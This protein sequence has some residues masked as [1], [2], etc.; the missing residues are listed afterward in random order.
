MLFAVRSLK[1][2]KNITTSPKTSIMGL[3]SF[4]QDFMPYDTHILWWNIHFMVLFLTHSV[5]V[6]SILNLHIHI[7]IFFWRHI[8]CL[9]KYDTDKLF[10]IY[11]N[12][13][14]LDLSIY[15]WLLWYA[16]LNLRVSASVKIWPMFWFVNIFHFKEL[17][18]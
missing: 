7:S 1:A 13:G 9:K 10:Y 3:L 6:H 14:T 17:L 11:L 12:H 8:F 4:D 2:T 16:F 15:I 5:Q 18:F